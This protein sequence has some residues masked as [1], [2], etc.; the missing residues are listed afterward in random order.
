MGYVG[1]V[2]TGEVTNPIGATLFGVCKTAANLTEKVAVI[3]ELLSI[4]NMDG[5]TIHVYFANSNSIAD[6]SSAHITLRIDNAESNGQTLVPPRQIM[7]S[8]S[9]TVG[10][11]PATSWNAGS[12]L[13]LT[14]HAVENAAGKWF[15]DGWLNTDTVY[16]N[17]TAST[18]GLM[19][20][21]DKSKLDFMNKYVDIVTV[22][23]WELPT[24]GWS[25]DTSVNNGPKYADYPYKAD[26]HPES[27]SGT[28]Y[29]PIV[30]FLPSDIEE[31]GIAPIAEVVEIGAGTFAV[32]HVR[33]YAETMPTSTIAIQ[34]TAL[35]RGRF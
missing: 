18:A 22:N 16:G 20:A 5:L 34:A 29:V 7:L 1:K 32:P 30:I 13:S 15:L 23:G 28:D 21:S 2:K 10:N 33:V 31:Y 4:D 8:G 27:L 35:L 14:Y 3:P 24:S 25:L 26:F 9:V 12:V 6:S 17:A 11:T 19:S